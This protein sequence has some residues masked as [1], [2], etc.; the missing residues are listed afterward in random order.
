MLRTHGLLDQVINEAARNGYKV[1]KGE[2]CGVA[3]G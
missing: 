2:S 1:Y 3:S